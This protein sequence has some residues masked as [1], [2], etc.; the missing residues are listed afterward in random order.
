[1]GRARPN[2]GIRCPGHDYTERCI[3]HIVL[4]KAPGIADFSRVT[5]KVGEAT[6]PPRSEL[7][8]TGRVVD[9]ALSG[10][11]AH[12]PYISI[13]RRCIMPDHVHFAI[14][15][16]E[17]TNLHLGLIV[18]KLK[19]DCFGGKKLFVDGYYDTFLAARGQLPRML[20]YI[21]D[22]PRRYLLR[23]QNRGFFVRGVITDGAQTLETFG[24]IDL[25]AE[26]QLEAV[27]ISR[28]F[29]PEQLI[30]KKRRWL[31]TVRN[32]GVLV[33][34]FVSESE[35]KVRDWAMA[36][37]GALIILTERRF[38]ER[39]KPSGAYFDLCAQGRLLEVSLPMAELTREGCGQLNSLAESIAGGLFRAGDL[40]G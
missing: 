40:R 7:S 3:Y 14:F 26:P 9:N 11:R 21:C 33:S 28:R 12:F 5:G 25:I 8:E 13:L 23:Q 32:D 17:K 34:P 15:V 4:N 24:N 22:N 20:D 39:Y 38:G 35:R 37:G 16:K 36:N 18:K 19:N 27:R 6:D 31:L 30:A 10:L 2:A 29:T 1:M